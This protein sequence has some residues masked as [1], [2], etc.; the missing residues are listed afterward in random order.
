MSLMI[1][2]TEH[3]FIC[4]LAMCMSSLEQCLFKSSA[5]FLVGLFSGIELNELFLNLGY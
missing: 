3:L 4:L 5:Q 2:D 1:T